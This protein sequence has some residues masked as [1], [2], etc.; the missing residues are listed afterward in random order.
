MDKFYIDKGYILLAR[1]MTEKTLWQCSPEVLRVAIYL[2]LEARHQKEPKKFTGFVLHRGE[3][4]TSYAN[5]SEDCS[6]FENRMIRKFPRSKV[7][8]ILDKLV[9]IEFIN[10]IS[11]TYGTH[12]SICNYS[13]YQ[14]PENYKSDSGRT[15]VEQQC[16]NSETVV[17]TLNNDNNGKNVNKKKD[18]T[19]EY[20]DRFLSFWKA[21]PKKTGKQKCYTLWKKKKCENG[22]YENIMAAIDAQKKWRASQP[23]GVFIPEWKNPET[24]LSKGCWE[25]EI[26][27]KANGNSQW[28]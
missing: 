11:D 7:G 10:R 27:D 20:S 12:I 22:H 13:K 25:D 23:Q 5:I 8:R 2:L 28:I 18:D 24:W 4:L 6:W 15:V 21:Y 14:L 9:E 17:G 1:I 19:S 26:S 16:D 3:V